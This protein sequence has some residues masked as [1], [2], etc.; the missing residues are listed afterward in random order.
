MNN[1]NKNNWWAPGLI[2]FTKISSFIAIP[3]IIALFV[4]KY[5]DKKYNTEPYIY[6]ICILLAFLSSIFLI[7]KNSKDYA[8][9]L[10][11][12]YKK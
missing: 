5:F 2:I 8:K 11:D 6:I 7:W 12:K 9:I 10:E 3:I 4:G 1:K